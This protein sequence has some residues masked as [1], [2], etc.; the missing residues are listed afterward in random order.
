M[1]NVEWKGI[2]QLQ[3]NEISYTYLNDGNKIIYYI[4]TIT[5]LGTYSLFLSDIWYWVNHK[6]NKT[7]QLRINENKSS[8]AV[9]G[10]RNTSRQFT[11]AFDVK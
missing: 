10:L 4:I 3:E 9:F 2:N 7:K 1:F 5:K 6:N 8:V 11:F